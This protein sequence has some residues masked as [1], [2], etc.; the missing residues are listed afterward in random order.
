MRD[1]RGMGTYRPRRTR[2]SHPLEA[3]RASNLAAGEGVIFEDTGAIPDGNGPFRAA[4]NFR[5]PPPIELP[6]AGD[7]VHSILHTLQFTY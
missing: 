7:R 5:Q 1:S 6:Y 2:D 4:E 3:Q